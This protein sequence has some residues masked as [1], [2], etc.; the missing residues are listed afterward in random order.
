MA[1]E[2]LLNELK[3]IE[4]PAE[5][6]WW[7]LAPLWQLMLALLVG[8]VVVGLVYRYRR[9]QHLRWRE[10]RDRLLLIR[11]NYRRHADTRATLQSLSAW[12]KQIAMAAFPGHSVAAMTGTAWA[13]FLERSTDSRIFDSESLSLFAAG[14]YRRDIDVDLDPAIDACERWLL[15]IGDMLRH[16]GQRHASA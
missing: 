12:L 7:L 1:P 2:D 15:E 3:D 8:S 6:S 16:G 9:R 11:E 10:A 13:E 14:V 5:P 4:V